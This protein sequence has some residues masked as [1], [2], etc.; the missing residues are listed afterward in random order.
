MEFEPL[1]P[2]PLLQLL[3]EVVDDEKLVAGRWRGPVGAIR[4]NRERSTR[5]SELR[6]E[7]PQ[8]AAYLRHV[9]QAL[10]QLGAPT[11]EKRLT[12]HPHTDGAE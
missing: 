10:V 9:D 3:E 2:H 6:S 4:T 12:A 8:P 1:V 7:N 11:A 5:V